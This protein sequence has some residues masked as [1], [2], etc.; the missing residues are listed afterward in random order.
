MCLQGRSQPADPALDAHRSSAIGMSMPEDDAASPGLL[1]ET[2]PGIV[3][4]LR[5]MLNVIVHGAAAARRGGGRPTDDFLHAIENAGR[6]AADMAESLHRLSRAESIGL[7]HAREA[8]PVEVNTRLQGLL[9]L[10]RRIVPD[11]IRLQLRCEAGLPRIRVDAARLDAAVLN[12]VT[13]ARDAL[14]GQRCAGRAA[15]LLIRTRAVGD[16]AHGTPRRLCIT[17][18]DTGAGIEEAILARIGEP[19]FTTKGS[20]GTGLGIR[21]VQAFARCE[22]GELKITSAVGC[23][24]VCD[25]YL[26]CP[27]AA[28]AAPLAPRAV[29]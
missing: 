26:P 3:H 18:A 6:T 23:G 25:L 13:N 28:A 15:E 12:M 11:W 9:P 17:V 8:I 16:A 22:G 14:V 20:R 19:Y 1:A 5:N 4:D 10:L 21:Q 24:T 7:H 2:L 27:G 29:Q